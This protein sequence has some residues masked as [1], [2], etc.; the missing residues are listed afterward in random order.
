V[1]V[2]YKEN[3]SNV[4][5]K[6]SFTEELG[7]LDLDYIEDYSGI[8]GQVI[9]THIANDVS[10][11]LPMTAVPAETPLVDNDVFEGLVDLTTIP[12]GR[13]AIKG[14]VKDIYGNYTILS[15]INPALVVGGERI[16]SLQ[17]VIVPGFP[18]VY[19]VDTYNVNRRDETVLA[20]RPDR[21]INVERENNK[22]TLE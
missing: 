18:V 21:V 7:L 1:T 2:F 15:E 6:L 11:V 12:N 8:D 20:S 17:V 16:I 5:I 10:Y 13:Y 9:M 3:Y 19:F 14:R 22:V 4:T